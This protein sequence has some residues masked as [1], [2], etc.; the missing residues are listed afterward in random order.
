MVVGVGI[1]G[2]GQTTLEAEACIQRADRV[3]YLVLEPTTERW[4]QQSNA[5]AVT[6][7]DCY[8]E[9]RNRKETYAEM[10]ARIVDAV[11]SGLRV[12][13]VFYGHPGVLVKSS[14]AAITILKKEG[15]RARMLPGVSADGC[16][17]ADLGFNPGDFGVQ[18]YEATDFL[19]AR[20]RFDPTSGLILWQVGVL[21]EVDSRSGVTCR[22]ERLAKLTA[23]L[24]RHYPATHKVVLYYAP[25]FPA[26]PPII[27]RVSLERLPVTKVYPL[28]MLFV[29]P[30][31]QRPPAPAIVR[32]ASET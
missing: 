28:A 24:G 29:P 8:R 27:K 1:T 21:G 30:L 13:A 10:T 17:Y 23:V 18:T 7:G 16:L 20:R 22:P 9:G 11:R 6:L 3:F 26:D 15:Y 25:M 31:E 32:W 12:C 4:I 5:N 19:R 2:V 14:H